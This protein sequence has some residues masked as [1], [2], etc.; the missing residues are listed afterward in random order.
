VDAGHE[1][2]NVQRDMRTWWPK[3]KRGG[4]MAG[5][6]FADMFDTFPSHKNHVSSKWGVKSAVAG[7]SKAVGS[8]FFLTFADRSHSTTSNDPTSTFEFDQTKGES[9]GAP[10]QRGSRL[11]KSGKGGWGNRPGLE[12]QRLGNAAVEGSDALANRSAWSLPGAGPGDRIVRP[13]EF[14]P[15]WYLF[16]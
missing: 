4:M 5:D 15:A 7:F 3:L 1:F 12:G 16:K 6:D 10:P 9:K 8:P 13:H 2:A 14:F 11:R